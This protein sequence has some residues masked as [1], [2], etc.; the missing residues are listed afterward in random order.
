MPS[1]ISSPP[2]L[3]I[4]KL[5]SKKLSSSVELSTV[6]VASGAAAG[7]GPVVV[8]VVVVPWPLV[9]GWVVELLA[10]MPILE[11]SEPVT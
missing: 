7:A 11:K 4:S 8:V 5:K 2:L 10:G 6:V 9:S 1:P 3:F